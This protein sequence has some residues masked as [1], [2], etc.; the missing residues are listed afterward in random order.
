MYFFHQF[1]IALSVV[2]QMAELRLGLTDLAILVT[3]D[4]DRRGRLDERDSENNL[5]KLQKESDE[6]ILF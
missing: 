6:I 2:V 3:V 1:S 5:R 4:N